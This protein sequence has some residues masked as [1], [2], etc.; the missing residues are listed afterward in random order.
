MPG[1]KVPRL[2]APASDSASV[3]G[4]VPP[5]VA[6][7]GLRPQSGD[8]SG[9]GLFVSRRLSVPSTA[10]VQMSLSVLVGALLY[11]RRVPS[12]DHAGPSSYTVLSS[13][14]CTFAPSA[15]IR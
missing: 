2:T 13:A 15:S 14:G 9:C 5:T 12:G 1:M 10:I 7:P 11:A 8:S 3:A 4:T 6:G